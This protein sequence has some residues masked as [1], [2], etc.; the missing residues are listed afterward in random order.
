[1]ADEEHDPK[2]RE[3]L[4]FRISLGGRLQKYLGNLEDFLGKLW[5]FIE[6]CVSKSV[7]R[8]IYF[9]VIEN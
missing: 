9:F 2:E 4:V 5:C 3:K 6:K 8:F 1:M 7:H